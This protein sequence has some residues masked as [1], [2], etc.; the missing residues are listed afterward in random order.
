M[1]RLTVRPLEREDVFHDMVRL[2]LDHR[3]DS[4]AG[5][6]IVIEAN[7]Q[8]VRALARGAPANSR[9]TIHMDLAMR[10]KLGV[11]LKEEVDFAILPGDMLDE[12]AWAWNATNAMPRIAARLAVLSLLLGLIGLVLGMIALAK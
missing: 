11:S 8:K 9:T 3:I 2:H 10:E 12:W 6:V 4:Q 5:R 1:P 7:G